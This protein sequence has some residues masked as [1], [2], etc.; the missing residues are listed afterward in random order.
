MP[1]WG[2]AEMVE[3]EVAASV[4]ESAATPSG[5]DTEVEQKAEESECECACETAGEGNEGGA[6]CT[7]GE[8]GEWEREA[9]PTPVPTQ[10]Q[11]QQRHRRK[12]KRPTPAPT[13]PY[14]DSSASDDPQRHGRSV[15]IPRAHA[16]DQPRH[17]NPASRPRG[18]KKSASTSSLPILHTHSGYLSLVGES[19][20]EAF[21]RRRHSRPSHTTSTFL[22]APPPPPPLR[23][24][25]AVLVEESPSPY[26]LML[27]SQRTRLEEKLAK[28]KLEKG[29]RRKRED[30]ERTEVVRRRVER[31]GEDWWREG[32]ASES[33]EV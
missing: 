11:A 5:E 9:E 27:L 10:V 14:G 18:H 25:A 16:F 12:K 31:V 6:E 3:R 26:T 22:D 21:E 24:H 33:E 8:E 1:R 30:Q 15:S 28:L 13:R 29:E 2:R 7:C 32:K 20:I 19:E 17:P 4:G 23:T